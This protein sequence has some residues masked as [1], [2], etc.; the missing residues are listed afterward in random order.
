MRIRNQRSHSELLRFITDQNL[1]K[2]SKWLRLAGYDTICHQ[3]KTDR[4][5]WDRALK[6]N[7]LVLT[8]KKNLLDYPKQLTTIQVPETDVQEQLAH[9]ASLLDLGSTEECCLKRC[10]VCNS[11][12]EQVDP[13]TVKD[14]VPP[15]VAETHGRFERCPGCGKIYWQG[16]HTE[17][18]RKALRKRTP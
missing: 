13:E 15:Y 11:R 10:T 18:I 14:R 7:R 17:R 1:A 16:S 12:L 5:L 4:G 3:G 2:L 9:L 6:E 8:R